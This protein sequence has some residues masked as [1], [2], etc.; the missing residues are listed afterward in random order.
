MPLRS[1]LQPIFGRL[2]QTTFPIVT[3]PVAAASSNRR[4]KQCAPF[5]IPIRA[6]FNWAHCLPR[7]FVRQNF[8]TLNVT[9][10]R[11]KAPSAALKGQ[12]DNS[13]RQ[14]RHERRP[15]KMS[16]NPTFPYSCF[17]ARRGKTGIRRCL[18]SV[19]LPWAALRL[20]GAIIVSS[21]QDFGWARSA[22][23]WPN[24]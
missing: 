3:W 17:A 18:L 7:F 6:S 14:A 24:Y 20:P 11:R 5:I 16:P 23:S 12:D 19:C 13:P 10:R 15:G 8:I 1:S 2:L 4:G 22:R 9:S 21:L